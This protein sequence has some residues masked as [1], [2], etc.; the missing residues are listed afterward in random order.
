MRKTVISMQWH[1]V[2]KTASTRSITSAQSEEKSAFHWHDCLIIVDYIFV[3]LDHFLHNLH[4]FQ[5]NNIIKLRLGLGSGRVQKFWTRPADI[6]NSMC[7]SPNWVIRTSFFSAK[8]CDYKLHKIIILALTL[9][10]ITLHNC[11]M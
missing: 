7:T 1:N 2:T 11:S 3:D 8:S 9:T 6:S 10:K 4:Q 5:H